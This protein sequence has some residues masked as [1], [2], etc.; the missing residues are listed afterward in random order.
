MDRRLNL[1]IARTSTTWSHTWQNPSRAQEVDWWETGNGVESL[2][3]TW[4]SGLPNSVTFATCVLIKVPMSIIGFNIAQ[5]TLVEILHT[6]LLGI[7]KYA[8][9]GSHCWKFRG[10]VPIGWI[11]GIY[12]P[13]RIYLLSFVF[14]YYGLVYIYWRIDKVVPYRIAPVLSLT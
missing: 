9:Y 13:V 4:R 10:S 8:W 1:A 2:S 7:V 12:D 3:Y 5:D 11:T 14:V 6:I